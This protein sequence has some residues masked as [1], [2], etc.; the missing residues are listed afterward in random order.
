MMKLVLSED[1]ELLQRKENGIVLCHMHVGETL[2]TLCEG[3][4]G[5]CRIWYGS[6]HKIELLQ[7]V[8]ESFGAYMKLSN[9]IDSE[10]TKCIMG[11]RLS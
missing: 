5:K 2:C 4:M 8:P 7:L 9:W 11:Q 3:H 6:G 1:G 10:M